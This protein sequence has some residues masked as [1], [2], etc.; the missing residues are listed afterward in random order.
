M[1]K[2]V[3]DQL[4]QPLDRADATPPSGGSGV[5]FAYHRPVLVAEILEAFA[6]ISGRL[7]LDGTLGGGGHSRALLEK[8]AKIIG[9]DRD[10]GAIGYC[11]QHLVVYDGDTV[12]F[13]RA[14]FRDLSSVLTNLKIHKMDGILLDLGVSSAQLDRA[15]RGFSF[16]KAGPLDMRMDQSAPETAASIVN[17]A[18]Q[19]ELQRMFW[20]YGEEPAARKVAAAIVKKREEK[21]FEDTLSLAQLVETVIPKHGPRHPATRVFQALRMAVNDELGALEEALET[22]AH[23]LNPGGRLAVITFHSL[24]DRIVKNFARETSA[25]TIDRPEW[26][27]P[28]PNPRHAFRTVQRRAIQASEAEQRENPRSRS[29]KLRVLERIS[30]SR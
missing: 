29:A 23:C 13:V 24:E 17:G 18:S 15:E 11:I 25:E 30:P 21:P 9:L 6:P 7:I 22:A 16:Q 14:N 28:R 26:P 27:Q 5:P 19:D 20:L 1:S 10:G 8:G 3:S 12:R 2:F 4:D